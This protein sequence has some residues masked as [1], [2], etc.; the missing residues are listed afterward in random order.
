MEDFYYCDNQ[1]F[2]Q[3]YSL[4]CYTMRKKKTKLKCHDIFAYYKQTN[5]QCYVKMTV[6]LN[7]LLKILPYQCEKLLLVLSIHLDIVQYC[8]VKICTSCTANYYLIFLRRVACGANCMTIW[9]ATKQSKLH[10][11]SASRTRH[12]SSS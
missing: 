7:E 4:T 9:L 6:T 8:N 5:Q 11:P 2:M 3:S 12:V 1:I 10:K